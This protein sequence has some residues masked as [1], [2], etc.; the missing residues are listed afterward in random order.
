MGSLRYGRN[1]IDREGEPPRGQ[2]SDR[3]A[4]GRRDENGGGAVTAG[5]RHGERGAS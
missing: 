4:R 3:S 1:R 2:G 5:R